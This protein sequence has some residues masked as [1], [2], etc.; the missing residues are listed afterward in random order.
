METMHS[1]AKPK[2]TCPTCGKTF[3]QKCFLNLH[4]AS[5]HKKGDGEIFTCDKCMYN[6]PY[7]PLLVQHCYIKHEIILPGW[8]LLT[9]D[10]CKTFKPPLPKLLNRHKK[11]KCDATIYDDD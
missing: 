11:R 8:N 10:I 9:C 5:T 6:S 4:E 1:D 7:K 3:R 2:F